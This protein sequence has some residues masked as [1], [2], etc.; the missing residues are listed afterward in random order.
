MPST[1]AYNTQIVSMYE[2]MCMSVAEIAEDQNCCEA[3]VKI[4]L[5]QNSK[6][7][8][9]ECG[10]INDDNLDNP[11][12]ALND[13]SNANEDGFNREDVNLANNIFREIARESDNDVLRLRAAEYIRDDYKGRKDIKNIV[14]GPQVNILVLNQRMEQ[15]RR[16]M[17]EME[18]RNGQ[19]VIDVAEQKVA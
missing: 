18:G 16:R 8:R 12:P 19:K 11:N 4:V 5:A 9:V 2:T 15:A 14:N 6:K 7:Y 10:F 3:A 13:T 1:S 17:A